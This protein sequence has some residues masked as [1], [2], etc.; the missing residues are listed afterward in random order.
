MLE[1]SADSQ[2]NWDIAKPTKETKEPSKFS[3]A[4]ESIVLDNVNVKYIR[5]SCK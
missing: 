4:M 5:C 2:A 3:F 1:V